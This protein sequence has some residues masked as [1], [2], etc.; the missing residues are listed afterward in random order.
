MFLEFENLPLTKPLRFRFGKSG[1]GYSAV[2]VQLDD[3]TWTKPLTRIEGRA[4][5]VLQKKILQDIDEN[6]D[7]DD[8]K[9]AVVSEM[10]QRIGIYTKEIERLQKNLKELERKRDEDE[11]QKKCIED[12]QKEL[13]LLR[14][15]DF[16][17]Q[18]HSQTQWDA[19]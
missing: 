16:V 6:E 8:G 2:P 7:Q 15:K 5:L 19:S 11:L 12:L 4:L 13:E 18:D 1:S 14:C 17:Q 10:E 3:D 9:E